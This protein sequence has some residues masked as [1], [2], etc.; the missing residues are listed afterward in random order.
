MELPFE[1]GPQTTLGRRFGPG[2]RAEPRAT[3]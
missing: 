3:R 1:D 2:L